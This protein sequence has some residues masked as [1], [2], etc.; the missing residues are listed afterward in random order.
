MPDLRSC[1]LVSSI[2]A[3]SA[4]LSAQCPVQWTPG[5]ASPILEGDVNV[6]TLWDPD[7]SGPA[8]QELILGGNFG[9]GGTVPLHIARHDFVNPAWLPVGGGLST[10]GDPGGV[11]A[12]TTAANGDLIAGGTS[13]GRWNGTSWSTLGVTHGYV[14]ALAGLPNGDIIAGGNLTIPGTVATGRIARWDG[15]SW[16]ALGSGVNA[17]VRALTTMPNG[18]LI[19]AGSFSNA[20]GVPVNNIARWDGTAWSAMG[21]GLDGDVFA[22]MTLPNGD[23]LAGGM[24]AQLFGSTYSFN[25]ARWDGS[26]WTGL[27]GGVGGGGGYVMTIGTLANGDVVVGGFLPA[28]GGLARWNGT[29][30]ASIPGTVSGFGAN[31]VNTVVT[32]PNG[33]LLAGGHFA[34]GGPTYSPYAVR[35]ASTCPG[36]AVS[37]GLG[38]VSSGGSNTLT[39][40]TLPWIDATLH[41]RGTGL[42]GLALVVA[43]TSFSSIAQGALP[44]A[45]VFT[46]APTGCD[47]LVAPDIL[48]LH[49]T[50]TGSV[51]SSLFLPSTP[52]IFGLTFF[53]QMVPIEVDVMGNFVEVTATNALQLTVGDF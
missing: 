35:V 28:H 25:I 10:L 41:T 11:Y 8:P 9:E 29:S 37:S 21:S 22:L 19:A 4:T 7:G 27:G 24:F 26:S 44:L 53:Q 45:N 40:V 51:D 18:D 3:V 46:Q 16:T 52:A 42:P 17:S 14:L 32:L 13:L 36:I 23:L 43:V 30:W 12:L 49:A 48:Q 31:W 6:A 38:C 2:L 1:L 33:E 5:A 47:L 39:A 20:G 15:T 34:Y 50:T